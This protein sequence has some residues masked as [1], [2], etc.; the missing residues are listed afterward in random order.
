MANPLAAARDLAWVGQHE[1]AIALCT[2]L[3]GASPLAPAQRIDLLDLRAESFVAQ[4]R[5]ADAAGDAAAMLVLARAQKH[6][7]LQIQAL[8]RQATTLMRQG[9]LNPALGVAAKAVELAQRTRHAPLLAQGLLHL[10]EIQ[11]RAA[12]TTTRP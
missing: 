11:I 9:Q 4:G 8:N 5:F 3:L 1:Q 7:T 10:G 2:Q 12:R 6:P